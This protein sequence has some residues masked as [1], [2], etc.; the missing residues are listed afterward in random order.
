MR[1]LVTGGRDFDDR[2]S[3]FDALDELHAEHKITL[4]VHG[5]TRGADSL[6]EEWGKLRDVPT[7]PCPAD[8]DRYGKA[9]G[10]IR[11]R[12]MLK[13]DPELVAAF[14]GGRGTTNMVRIARKAG[15]KV[16]EI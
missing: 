2:A 16:M 1:L 3:V 12:L 5:A 14:P 6:A 8:W 13:H 10:A 7:M 11:N 4:V 15:I 9:A